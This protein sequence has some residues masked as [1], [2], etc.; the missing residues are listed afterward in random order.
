VE[1]PLTMIFI[2]GF[3]IQCNIRLQLPKTSE[4]VAYLNKE[5]FISNHILMYGFI[6]FRYYN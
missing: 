1:I 4:V 6:R 2:V 5:F 3:I